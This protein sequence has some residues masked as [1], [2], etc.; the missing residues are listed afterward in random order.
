MFFYIKFKANPHQCIETIHTKLRHSQIFIFRQMSNIGQAT[1][2]EK[3][4]IKQKTH[5]R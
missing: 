3:I 5:P 4:K 1:S 2:T